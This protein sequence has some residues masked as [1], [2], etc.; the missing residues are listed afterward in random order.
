MRLAQWFAGVGPVERMGHREIVIIQ[1]LP[2]LLFQ[3]SDGWK[4]ASSDDLPH[5][6]AKQGL[7]LVQPRAVFGQEHEAD[8]MRYVG[9]ELATCRLTFQDA[10]LPLFFP[11]ADSARIALPPIPPVPRTNEC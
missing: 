7:D 1:E 2:K 4:T 3:V 8:A 11:T 10:F 5:D 6:D 9:Q